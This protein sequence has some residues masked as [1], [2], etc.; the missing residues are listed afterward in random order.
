MVSRSM[1]P[2]ASRLANS[3]IFHP[4]IRQ[5][6][7]Q[8]L[9]AIARGAPEFLQARTPEVGG[10]AFQKLNRAAVPIE[11]SAESLHL[12]HQR[13]VRLPGSREPVRAE[14]DEIGQAAGL[15]LFD[16]GKGGFQVGRGRPAAEAHPDQGFVDRQLVFEKGDLHLVRL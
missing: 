5:G 9:L 4:Q 6:F 14:G 10:P 7:H 12:L 8:A 11:F 13:A 2:A 15:G 3:L 1:E 16:V